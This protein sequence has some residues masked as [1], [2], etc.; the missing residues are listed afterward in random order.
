MLS[1]KTEVG[2]AEIKD[3]VKA[4]RMILVTAY[5]HQLDLQDVKDFPQVR[6]I[7][8]EFNIDLNKLKKLPNPNSEEV[9]QGYGYVYLFSE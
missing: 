2:E 8:N 4:R 9:E 5:A 1:V 3:E 7:V 6:E